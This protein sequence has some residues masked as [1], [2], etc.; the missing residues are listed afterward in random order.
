MNLNCHFS[1]PHKIGSNSG[2]FSSVANFSSRHLSFGGSST[3]SPFITPATN[4]NPKFT[5]VSKIGTSKSTY[6]TVDLPLCAP[7]KPPKPPEKPLTPYMRYSKKHEIH[8]CGERNIIFYF[9]VWEKAR[10]SNPDSKMW[11]IGKVVGSMWRELPDKDKQVFFDEYEAEKLEYD[12]AVK[13]Y[14]HSPA[15]LAYEQQLQ[16]NKGMKSSNLR[17]KNLENELENI[18]T[19]FQ[20][21]KRTLETA[22]NTFV[23]KWKKISDEAKVIDEQQFEEMVARDEQRILKAY[24]EYKNRQQT[25]KGVVLGDQDHITLKDD[26]RI[27]LDNI[28]D[29][30]TNNSAV[31]L[32]EDER[33]SF[34]GL[35]I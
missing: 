12:K 23:A 24:T 18:E 14:K 8:L 34:S 21:K 22:S 17:D 15:Y 11:D 31:P 35:E 4:A 20:A 5:P 16:R 3:A 27:I 25:E 2:G 13:I 33:V 1:S 30:V 7:I 32:R 19:S 26:V 28:L 29:K 6:A 10:A 9:P